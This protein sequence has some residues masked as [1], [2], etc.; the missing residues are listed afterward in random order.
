MG[1]RVV[2]LTVIGGHSLLAD[3]LQRCSAAPAFL[4][5][6]KSMGH[7]SGPYILLTIQIWLKMTDTCVGGLGGFRGSVTGW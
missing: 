3:S 1:Q 7:F 4:W 2:C 6:S 5:I